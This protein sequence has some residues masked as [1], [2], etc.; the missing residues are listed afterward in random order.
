[1]GLSRRRM[2]E[3]K[4]VRAWALSR[5]GFRCIIPSAVLRIR[6]PFTE[7]L[8]DGIDDGNPTP[9]SVSQPEAPVPRRD[10]VLPPG[11]FLRE[12]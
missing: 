10:P 9:Q 4:G 7:D 11:R 12:F 6:V 2:G 1:M 5:C 3:P 8:T